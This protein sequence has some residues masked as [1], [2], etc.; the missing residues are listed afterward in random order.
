M[1]DDEQVQ[2]A[3]QEALLSLHDLKSLAAVAKSVESPL[4]VDELAAVWARRGSMLLLK[5]VRGARAAVNPPDPPPSPSSEFLI[6]RGGHDHDGARC[7]VR[8]GLAH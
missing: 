4:T 1:H 6:E 3:V 2:A 5:P 8:H 7:V